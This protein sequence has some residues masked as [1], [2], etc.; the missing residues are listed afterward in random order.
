MRSWVVAAVFAAVVAG[1]NGTSEEKPAPAPVPE[2]PKPAPEPA[3][4]IPEAKSWEVP[5]DHKPALLDPSLATEKAPAEFKVKFET[6]KGDFTVLVH[7]D[8]APNGADRF[9]NLVQAG[10]Y[11]DCRFF[12]VVSGFMAQFGISPYP[13]VNDKWEPARIQDDPVKE[14]NTRGR[15]TFATAGPNTRTTQLFINFGDNSALDGQ[16]FAPFGEVVE[17]MEVVDQLYSGYGDG[18]PRGRGPN[19]GILQNRGNQYLDKAFPELDAIKK[20]TVLP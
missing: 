9:F 3:T 6:T 8:W 4:P 16:G 20:A 7:R 5:A 17:G 13:P 11:D 19:Q 12:R 10:F 1:C 18:P 15:L 14:H 2:A